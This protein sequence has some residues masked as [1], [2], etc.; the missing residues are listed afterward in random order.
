MAAT[1]SSA[2]LSVCRTNGALRTSWEPST[3]RTLT[4]LPI[5]LGSGAE[6]AGWNSSSPDRGEDSVAL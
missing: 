4:A 2:P 1:I 3:S 6:P 5:Y